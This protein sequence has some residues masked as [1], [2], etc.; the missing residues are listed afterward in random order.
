MRTKEYRNLPTPCIFGAVDCDL[1]K[2]AYALNSKPAMSLGEK[3]LDSLIRFQS[4][5]V[6][7]D[8]VKPA[9]D[10]SKDI[11]LRFYEAKKMTSNIKVDLN[12]DFGSVSEVNM[13]ENEKASVETNPQGFSFTIKPFEIKTFKVSMKNKQ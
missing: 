11:I 13:L 4:S 10:G 2:Q 9:E 7:L 1:I 3:H 6:F 8:T 5:N 12:F